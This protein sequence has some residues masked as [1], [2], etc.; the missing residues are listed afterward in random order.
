ME[1]WT[2]SQRLTAGDKLEASDLGGIDRCEHFLAVLSTNAINS[3]WVAKEIRYALGKKKKVIPILL[4]PIEPSALGLWFPKKSWFARMLSFNREPVALKVSDGPGGLA[5]ALPDLLAAL[6]LKQPTEKLVALQAQVAPIADLVLK[7]TDPAINAS[8]GKR[9]ATAVATLVYCPPD[10]GPEVEGERYSFTSPLGPIEADDLAWYLER[11]INWPSGIF[12]ERAGRIEAALPEWGKRLYGSLDT[13]IAQHW[14]GASPEAERRLTIKVDRK[15]IR[16]ASE[17]QQAAADEAASLLLS[18][19]W[20]LIHDDG[21]YLFL[22]RSGVRVRRSLPKHNPHKA[23][24]TEPPIRVLLVSPRPEDD[25]AAYLDHRASARPLVEA[26]TALGELAEFTILDPPTFPALEAELERAEANPYHVVHFDGHG[27]YDRE[28]NHGLGALCF[29]EPADQEKLERRRSQLITADKIAGVMRDRRVPLF[30]LEACQTAQAGTDP[31]ASVAGKLLESGV[32][33]VAAMSHSVLVETARRFVTVFYTELL[34]GKRVGQSMLLAQRAL[35]GDPVRGRVLNVELRLQ[36]WFVPVLFQ[37]EQDPQLIRELPAEEVRALA[38]KRRALALGDVPAEPPYQFQG[39][40][41]ELLSAERLLARE[42]YVV[43]QGEGG[44]GKTTLAAELARWLVLTRRFERAAFVRLDLE[45]DARKILFSIGGQ[46]VPNYV[47]R[48]AQGEKL[49]WQLVEQALA[50]QR[51]VIVLDNLESVLEPPPDSEAHAAFDADVLAGIFG[52]CE[53]LVKTGHTRLILTS[54]EALPEPFAGNRLTI[55][56]LDRPDA[57]RLVASVLKTD[58]GDVE[59]EQEIEAL[60]DAVGCHARALVLLAG[61]VAATG[62]RR[63]TENLHRLMTALHEKH[64]DDR[65]RSLF[66]SVQLSLRRLPAATRQKIRPLGV[67]QGGGWPP[68]IA[69]ALGLDIQKDEEIALARELIGVGLA[70]QLPFGYLRFDPA[71]APALLSEMNPEETEAARAAWAEAIAAETDFLYQEQTKDANLAQNLCLL[72]LANLVAALE[73]SAKTEPP[74]RVVELATR[75]EALI[76]LLNRPNALARAVAIRNASAHRLGGWSHGRFEAERA[77]VERLLE[78]GDYVGA[79]RAARALWQ[80]TEQ[81]GESAYQEADYDFAM[82][83][84]SLGRSLKGIGAAEEALSYLEEA[85]RRFEMLGQASM[86]NV[87]LTDKADCFRDLGRYDEAAA[88]YETA[89]TVDDQLGDLRSVGVDK[90]QLA[91]VRRRQRRY[92][93]ALQ[94]YSEVRSIFKDLGEVGIMAAVWHQIGMVHQEAGQPDAAEHAY[95]ESLKISVQTGDALGEAQTLGQ[96]GNLYSRVGQREDAVR[97]YRHA[98]EI[99]VR[100]GDMRYESLDHSNTAREL[101]AL[102]RFAEARAELERAIECLKPFGHVAQPWTTFYILS[103]LE[104]AVG[105]E[106]AAENAMAQAIEAYRAYRSDGGAPQPGFES[107]EG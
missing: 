35:A 68:I 6:G 45:G 64:P 19:P 72:D 30:F 95:Q 3:T 12:Q 79:V 61:E 56:R 59:S 65:E 85:R 4:P 88:A 31:T 102:G 18:L 9:R 96:L 32:A 81:A 89:I 48:A 1:V 22:G 52:L 92:A 75:L 66:A 33:S 36:D 106:A 50:E 84:F 26:L 98:A 87:A 53:K 23:I 77:A 34:S 39:R 70:E 46:L 2:D 41:R 105:N 29:E 5:A 62:V 86:A 27:V 7:L 101:I 83:Q 78:Q 100:L 71:L 11:Y 54:R 76:A 10:G 104:R 99:H 15:L 42:R 80:K 13:S 8:D 49:A 20:E 40:S 67:F 14:K 82:A 74:E 91:T 24:A 94:L 107:W 25:S 60:V 16:G 69:I 21:G 44:E 57:I 37:E 17:L 51:T 63:A 73:R 58:S 103:D 38:E 97:C 55:G 93:D 28:H 47:T 43:V 90:N